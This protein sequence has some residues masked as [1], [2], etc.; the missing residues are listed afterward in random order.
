MDSNIK[1][2][3]DVSRRDLVEGAS[4]LGLAVA[5]ISSGAAM[6]LPATAAQAQAQAMETYYFVV[7]N[8]PA[9]M[10]EREYLDWYDN[11]HIIDVTAI[12]GFVSGQRFVRNDTQMYPGTL[13]RLPNYLTLY[14]VQTNDLA[15]VNAEISKRAQTGV[16]RFP[17]P[18][19]IE[20]DTGLLYWYRFN[21]REIKRTLPLPADFAGKKLLN[22]V[23]M[24]FM[25]AADGKQKEWEQ[26]YDKTHSPN[27]LTGNGIMTSQRM[28]LALDA[29]NAPVPPTREM[30]LFTARIPEGLAADSAAPKQ[31]PGA[32]PVSQKYFPQKDTRGYTYREIGPL[33]THKQAV[34]K[35]ALFKD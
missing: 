24:V 1:A 18:P 28:T 17:K 3:T 15:A 9:P 21:A 6:L 35:K 27:M 29:P 31:E 30:V 8:N 19:L 22:Y 12:P 20:S 23:H 2:S 34:A 33:V 13:P 16:T 7:F 11:R 14:T 10:K 5:I 26:W 4:V 25:N 32:L